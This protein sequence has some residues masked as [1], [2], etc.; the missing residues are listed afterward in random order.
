M[1]EKQARMVDGRGVRGTQGRWAAASGSGNL[2]NFSPYPS[3]SL[4]STALVRLSLSSQMTLENFPPQVCSPTPLGDPKLL[5]TSLCTGL[6]SLWVPPNLHRVLSYGSGHPFLPPNQILTYPSP[7][8]STLCLMSMYACQV[9]P[10]V[11][12]SL[13]P[14]GL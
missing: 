2:G 6:Q 12:D 13:G 1:N 5:Q 7:T 11:S 10:V 8:I 3:P 9:A 4:S 14:Y